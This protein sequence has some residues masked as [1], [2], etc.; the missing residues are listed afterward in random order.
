MHMGRAIMSSLVAL[1]LA[2]CGGGGGGGSTP[3]SGGGGTPTG[4]GNTGTCSYASRADWARGVIQ[5][6]YL[7]PNGLNTAAN[8]ASYTDLQDYIDALVRPSVTPAAG[9][10]GGPLEK[11]GLTYITSIREENALINSGSNAGIGIRLSYDTATNRVFVAEAFENA[12]G[13]A[14]GMDRGTQIISIGGQSVAALMSSGGAAAV[15]AALGPSE[16]GVTRTITFRTA[17]G[18]EVTR[19]ITKQDYVLDPVSDRYGIRILNDGTQQVGYVNLRTFIVADAANQLRAGFAQFKAAG[20]TRII[21]DFRYNGGGLVSNADLLTDL[22]LAANVGQ[23]SSQT[24][25]RPSKASE[26]E[27][28]RITARTEAVAATRVAVIGREGTASA[29]EL[30]ANNLIPYLGGGLALVGE[31]TFGK[32][33]GQFAFD[34]TACDDRLRA[35]A[36][37]TVN[38]AGNGEY[39]GGLASV[40]PVTCAAGDDFTHQLGDPEETSI[41]VALDFLAGRSCTPISQSGAGISGQ[42]V[43][44]GARQIQPAQPNVVQRENPGLF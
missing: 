29:S 26:N 15:S 40:V 41:A 32:P 5:E 3:T 8:P 36:F 12:P 37:K 39:Y 28:T 35:I 9:G 11:A 24:V 1:S 16:P 31:N 25:L 14:V 18:S 27:T 17:G 7:F 42:S 20:I 2:A 6:W 34:R 43:K 21:L 33:V 38:A 23:V 19:D 22:L 13:F 4:G 10:T 30:V 44:A